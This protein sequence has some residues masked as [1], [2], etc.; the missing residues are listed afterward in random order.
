[1]IAQIRPEGIS[2]LN[3]LATEV[4]DIRL[5]D[6]PGALVRLNVG[7][8]PILSRI[9]RRSAV[10]LDLAPGKRV[11]AVLK[12]VSVARDSVGHSVPVEGQQG[13]KG[14]NAPGFPP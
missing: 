3:V 8:S 7:G 9:T 1:M 14:T 4:G 5:G 6:G 13:A 10:A 12:A 11:H 2:T